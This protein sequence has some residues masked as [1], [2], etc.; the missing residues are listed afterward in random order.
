MP[1]PLENKAFELDPQADSVEEGSAFWFRDVKEACEFYL[2]Y[3][4]DIEL[5]KEEQFYIKTN[6]YGE[7][8]D[9]NEKKWVNYQEW[10]FKYSFSD[11]FA[12]KECG[13]VKKKSTEKKSFVEEHYDPELKEY[14]I[15]DEDDVLFNL[16]PITFLKN[17][18]ERD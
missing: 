12:K 8:W 2:K 14:P 17:K 1:E 6:V 11:V 9:K 13:L 7:V 10:L 18:K 3:L 4:N 5:F 15:Y 16:F